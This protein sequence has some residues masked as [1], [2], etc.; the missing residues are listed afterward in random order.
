L[1]EITNS[2]RTKLSRNCSW[3][4]VGLCPHE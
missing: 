3:T 1:K 4:E 2:P